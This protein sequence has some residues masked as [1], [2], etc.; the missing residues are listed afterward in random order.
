MDWEIRHQ[1][2]LYPF[3]VKALLSSPISRLPPGFLF[4]SHLS[5]DAHVSQKKRFIS[6]YPSPLKLL[7][8]VVCP[9]PSIRL[10]P[11]RSW[12]RFLHLKIQVRMDSERGDRPLLESM[13]L[14]RLSNLGRTTCHGTTPPPATTLSTPMASLDY[15]S[16]N[17]PRPPRSHSVPR[18]GVNYA[19]S[20]NPDTGIRFV[21]L[22]L[23]QSIEPPRR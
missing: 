10:H 18:N 12:P 9:C 7:P 21:T 3:A 19:V 16:Q 8:V 6:F 1:L 15:K 17:T 23:M 2:G 22:I 5:S 11:T 14:E 20:W 4:T 13:L